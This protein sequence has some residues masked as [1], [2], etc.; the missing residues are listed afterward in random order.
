MS[1]STTVRGRCKRE[2]PAKPYPEFPLF[3]HATRRWAKK[4]KGRLHYFGP[5]ADPQ[6]ALQRYLDQKDDL[7]AGR[8]PR[9]QVD[10]VTVAD[11]ANAFLNAKRRLLDNGEIGS[12]M[13]SE[14][15]GAC[16]RVVSA[17]GRNRLVDDLR[18]ADFAALRESLAKTRGAVA[19]GNEIQRVRTLFKFAYDEGGIDKPIRYGQS[20]RKPS[21]KAVR[22]ARASNGAR[23]FTASDIRAMLDAADVP[24]RAVIL[25]GINAAFGQSDC[26]ALPLSAIDLAGG[27]V[28]FPRPKTGIE[29]RC[30]LWPETVAAL[31][32]AIESRPK[33][34][35]DAD[36]RLAFITKFGRPLV[37]VTPD[38]KR[39]D[40]VRRQFDK[41]ASS[42]DAKRPGIAFYSLR[43][44][45]RTV[46]DETLDRPALD[47]IMGHHD[48]SM[49]AVYRERISDERLQAVT[50]HVH[51]W[52]FCESGEGDEPGAG[53]GPHPL[54]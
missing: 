12:R 34:K 50:D 21:A 28:S 25:L 51:D 13:F 16:S 14:Y 29:R 47:R 10:G 36:D 4:I 27:W 24:L 19:L 42:I 2:K 20:F 43:R 3:P 32:A 37:Y 11:I 26:A 41:L 35:D 33:P 39:S 17:F 40:A 44:T 45:F 15:H 48:R 38:G 54:R 1:K 9:P 46:A 49:G 30:A 52:L 6:G 5:W 31:R 7:H 8:T 22:L 23:I 53:V 18:P